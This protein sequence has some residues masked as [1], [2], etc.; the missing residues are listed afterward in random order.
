MCDVGRQVEC[1]LSDCVLQGVLRTFGL[2]MAMMLG[3]S[4]HDVPDMGVPVV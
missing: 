3:H 2:S 1:C 4:L